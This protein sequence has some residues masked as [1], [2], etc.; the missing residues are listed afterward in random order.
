MVMVGKEREER[1]SMRWLSSRCH[2]S[3]DRS[4]TSLELSFSHQLCRLLSSVSSL[5]AAT[6]EQADPSRAA[7]RKREREADA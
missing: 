5:D 6:G 4:E 2:R 7:Q 3:N 1:L